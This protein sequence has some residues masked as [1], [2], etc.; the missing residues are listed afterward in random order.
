MPQFIPEKKIHHIKP[1]E[2]K[3]IKKIK[4]P[5]RP[6]V[7]QVTSTTKPTDEQSIFKSSD[8]NSHSF[9]INLIPIGKI[10]DIAKPGEPGTQN[11]EAI[12]LVTFPP[13]YP[14][15][16]LKNNI[17]GHVTFQ[18]DI[19]TDGYAHNIQIIHADA[20]KKEG[21]LLP[22]KQQII[23]QFIHTSKKSIKKWRFRPRVENGQAFLQK[24]MTYTLKFQIPE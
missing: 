24:N 13:Q 20:S 12:P 3:I 6:N 9:K 18:F 17:I 4:K 10:G 22:R 11:S 8:M 16:P 21:G 19:S 1:E 7:A 23:Q 2:P 15:E 5:I 14:Q